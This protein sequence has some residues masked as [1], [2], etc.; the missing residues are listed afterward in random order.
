[1]PTVDR[2]IKINVPLEMAHRYLIDATHLPEFCLNLDAVTDITYLN[3]RCAHFQWKYR[4]C[5]VHFE[6]RAEVTDTQRQHR[7]EVRF[8]GGILGSAVWTAQPLD[9]GILLMVTV[10]YAP[11]APL[12]RK[13]SE[14]EI[15]Q[16][17]EHAVERMLAY[18]KTLLESKV[19]PETAI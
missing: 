9:D 16:H 8:W 12:L 17:N 3:P 4:M 7:V 19:A 2:S 18:F 1:M 5:G 10:D 15:I 13:H 14:D 11:P 6:G